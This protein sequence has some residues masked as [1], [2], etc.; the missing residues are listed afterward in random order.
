MLAYLFDDRHRQEFNARRMNYWDAYIAEIF[1]LLGLRGRALSTGEVER[2]GLAGVETLL[3]GA[4]SGRRLSPAAREAV[5]AWVE[6]GGALIGFAT[7]GLDR[8]FGIESLAPQAM[9]EGYTA[10]TKIQQGADDWAINGYVELRS[11]ALTRE[12]HHMLHLHQRIPVVSDIAIARLA[13]ATELGVLYDV[14]QK[15]L[16]LPI[17][18]WNAFGKGHAAYFAFDLPKTVWLMH[19]GRPAPDHP[20]DG[21]YPRA[22][23]MSILGQNSKLVP[24]ADE[25]CWLLRNLVAVKPHAFICPV[26]PR[27]GRVADAVLY[28]GGDEYRGPVELSI[29]AAEFM[30]ELGIPYQ[31]NLESDLHPMTKEEHAYIRSLGTEVSA[32]YHLYE[33]D[34]F[35]MKPEHYR[36]QSDKFLERFGYRPVVSV[37]HCVRW[38]GWT[39]PAKWMRDAGA[40]ADNGFAGKCVPNDCHFRN[41]ASFAFGFGTSYPFY[42]WDDW[43]GGNARIDFMEQPIVGYEIGHRTSTSVRRDPDTRAFEEIHFI[44]GV[45]VRYHLAVNLFYHPYYLVNS[46]SCRDALRELLRYIGYLGATVAHFNNRMMAEWWDARHAST[47]GAPE[48]SDSGLTVACDCRHKGGMTVRLPLP[49]GRPAAAQCN[50]APTGHRQVREFGRDWLLAV[51]PEGC[52]RLDVRWASTDSGRTA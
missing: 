17:I 28:Y 18:A 21:K 34:G 26:P 41:S 47:V 13:G 22:H 31:T 44:V 29:K 2:G 39:E 15:L 49:E 43:R 27:D 7:E 12:V 46:E 48:L 4:C 36:F 24:Y 5:T 45:A 10:P 8:V 20:E 1:E 30:H 38:K 42:F 52:S 50:G 35:T 25:L 23:D 32:Y 3:I 6:A 11:H 14:N 16:C 37:N 40:R 9:K 19:Q 51:V 33:H